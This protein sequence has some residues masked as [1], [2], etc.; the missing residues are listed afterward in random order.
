MAVVENVLM[1]IV[2]WVIVEA[3]IVTVKLFPKVNVLMLRTVV[4]DNA[5]LV[6]V[7]MQELGTELH[8]ASV[9]EELLEVG[10]RK[11]EQT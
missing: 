6:T 1:E 9:E 5:V 4:I 3:G 11:Q 7:G 10:F 2:V 8:V